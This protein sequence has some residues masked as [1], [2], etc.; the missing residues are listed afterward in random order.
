VLAAG[1]GTRLR[2]ITD[3]QPTILTEVNGILFI[4]D[5][6]DNPID[7]GA[8]ELMVIGYKSEQIIDRYSDKHRD[9]SITH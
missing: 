9:V 5:I 4:K 1:K 7:S 6:V 3:D 2:P 8:P